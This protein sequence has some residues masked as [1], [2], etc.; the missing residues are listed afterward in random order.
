[1]TN[2]VVVKVSTIR[3]GAG[4]IA[5]LLDVTFV[6]VRLLIAFRIIWSGVIFGH[7]M[8]TILFCFRTRWTFRVVFLGI[9][10]TGT[11]ALKKQL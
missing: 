6:L 11:H 7:L 9:L 3:V 10:L 1:M 8:W 4:L 2:D 5:T